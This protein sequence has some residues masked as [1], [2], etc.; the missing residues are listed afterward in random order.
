MLL[1]LKSLF[2]R[3]IDCFGQLVY[4]FTHLDAFLVHCGTDSNVHY[5]G[6]VQSIVFFVFSGELLD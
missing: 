3:D 6:V 5:T 2:K 4:L 1:T